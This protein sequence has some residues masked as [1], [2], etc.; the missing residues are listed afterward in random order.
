VAK[1][2]DLTGE[3]CGTPTTLAST[4]MLSCVQGRC[5]FQMYYSPSVLTSSLSD[6]LKLCI[7]VIFYEFLIQ[8]KTVRGIL[9][10]DILG[11]MAI[12]MVRC[13]CN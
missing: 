9:K 13:L 12:S 6:L 7:I 5:F 4:T 2:R 10:D 8:T 3:Y 11:S 1:L